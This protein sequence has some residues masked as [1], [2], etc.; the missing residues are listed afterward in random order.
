MTLRQL[1]QDI[2]ARA[3]RTQYDHTYY[4]KKEPSDAADRDMSDFERK[5]LLSC[6]VRWLLTVTK[7]SFARDEMTG[8]FRSI[9]SASG[10][11]ISVTD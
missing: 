5:T 2:I 6:I 4:S 1:V 11:A 8:S 9:E 7:G 3:K 10:A